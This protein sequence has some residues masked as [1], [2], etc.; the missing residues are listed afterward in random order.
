MHFCC[1]LDRSSSVNIIIKL[2][3]R[4]E[5]SRNQVTSLGV[6]GRADVWLPHSWMN[7]GV[8]YRYSVEYTGRVSYGELG[9]ASVG[10][11]GGLEAN[12]F[13]HTLH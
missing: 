7:K 2:L 11:R 8:A 13:H 3:V 9:M 5:S 1:G 10:P 12:L 6:K 4:R